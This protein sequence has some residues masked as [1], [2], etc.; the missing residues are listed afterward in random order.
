MAANT[1]PR[2]GAPRFN[3][4]QAVMILLGFL[5]VGLVGGGAYLLSGGPEKRAESATI[6]HATKDAEKRSERLASEVFAGAK[7][8]PALISAAKRLEQDEGVN[9]TLAGQ[10]DGRLQVIAASSIAL[11]GKAPDGGLL[12]TLKGHKPDAEMSLAPANHPGSEYTAFYMT[13]VAKKLAGA[14]TAIA[15]APVSPPPPK[16]LRVIKR[17]VKKEAPS[18]PELAYRI[19]AGDTLYKI[20]R[21]HYNNDESMFS[22]I[23]EANKDAI[24]LDRS[25]LPVG[26]TIR[27]PAG[28]PR[29]MEVEDSVTVYPSNAP[30]VVAGDSHPAVS[31][32]PT[33]IALRLTVPVANRAAGPLPFL[34]PR[35]RAFVLGLVGALIAGLSWWLAALLMSRQR[36]RELDE[37]RHALAELLGARLSPGSHVLD[38]TQLRSPWQVEHAS[39]VLDGEDPGGSFTDFRCFTDARLGLFIGDATGWNTNALVGRGLANAFWR[40]RASENTPPAQTMLEVNRL[41]V[42]YISQG[43][44]VTAFYAQVDLMSGAVTYA[45]A[46]HTGAFVLGRRGGLTMLSSRGMP[47]GVGTELFSERLEE[48]HMRLQEGESLLIL[49]DGVLKAEGEGGEPFGV[50]RLEKCLRERPGCDADAIIA[51]IREA[52]VQFVG[53][54]TMVDE[55]AMLCLRLVNPLVLYPRMVVEPIG[56]QTAPAEEH[57]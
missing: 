17:M 2:P 36:K 11:V 7:D 14:P 22:K 56:P 54:D 32:T 57:A 15:A 46:A 8:V 51:T 45:S 12:E 42:D 41:L 52:L 34:V 31:S 27:L 49:T 20:A 47:L 48:G 19:K 30:V 55:S 40:S 24:G 1:S 4:V 28:A 38:R 43:D 21:E 23:W 16:A 29:A 33:Q 53:S 25:R 18:T 39:L 3:T 9:Y 35:Q 44:H 37:Q 26:T 5:N 6:E 13:K 50:A 10:L